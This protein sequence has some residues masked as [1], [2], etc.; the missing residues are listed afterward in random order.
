MLVNGQ[1]NFGCSIIS[2]KISRLGPILFLRT[3]WVLGIFE[4]LGSHDPF[5]MVSW[6]SSFINAAKYRLRIFVDS[7][8][9][10][11]PKNLIYQGRRRLWSS[12]QHGNTRRFR[13]LRKLGFSTTSFL[14]PSYQSQL[15]AFVDWVSSHIMFASV[16]AHILAEA[17]LPSV[18]VRDL[19]RYYYWIYHYD[20]SLLW[21]YLAITHRRISAV[22][23]TADVIVGFYANSAQRTRSMKVGRFW[24]DG[25][26]STPQ[27]AIWV[28]QSTAET[29]G[30]AGDS[31]NQSIGSIRTL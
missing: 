6:A 11:G 4:W 26:L 31:H 15:I 7:V 29:L 1:L 8:W 22:F 19:T 27:P 9:Y 14:P 23:W 21:Q 10:L 25:I 28:S 13:S 3:F 2:K 17:P 5:S 16:I 30:N 18:L 20:P 12:S 24:R